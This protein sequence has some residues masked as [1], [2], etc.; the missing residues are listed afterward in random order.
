MKGRHGDGYQA[1]RLLRA[2]VPWSVELVDFRQHLWFSHR[3]H[4]TV[5][6]LALQ[7]FAILVLA[8]FGARNPA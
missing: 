5:P 2:H 6:M 4:I 7:M 1:I 8:L 3:P